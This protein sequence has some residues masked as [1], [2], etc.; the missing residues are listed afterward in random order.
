MLDAITLD[1]LRAFVAVVDEGSFSAA[2]RK[3]HRVQSAVSHAMQS[4]EGQ[5]GLTLWDRST[6][7]PTLT[8]D[9]RALLAQARRVISEAV[10]LRQTAERLKGG[11]EA[12]VS[13][14]VDAI[15][16]LEALADSLRDFSR[17]WPQVGLRLD[18]ETMGA[19]A[20]AVLDGR[21]TLGVVGPTG[22][23]PGLVA[24]HIG[25]VKMVPVVA[26]SHPLAALKGK[27]PAARLEQETQVVLS[28]RGQ[29]STPDQG[30][31]AARVLRVAD[32]HAKR[33]LLLKGLG[34]G[35]LPE[36]LLRADLRAGR[37]KRIRPAMWGP[38][39]HRLSLSL[40]HRPEIGLGPATRWLMERLTELCRRD[41]GG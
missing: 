6:R 22:V 39:E 17:E 3:L 4:L 9:G 7:V 37:L 2:G 26:R 15:F 12:S 29:G 34:W 20:S 38:D 19:V 31:I 32:L 30:V 10:E 16:P 35:N 18:T 13:L 36:H 11:V 25:E 5:L 8:E 40:V 24:T 33:A 14:V 1:Q 21:S 28:E 27:A 41:L 23:L